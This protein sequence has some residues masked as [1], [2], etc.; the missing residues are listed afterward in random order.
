MTETFQQYI[1]RILDPVEHESEVVCADIHWRPVL[2]QDHRKKI[3]DLLRKEFPSAVD[4]SSSRESTLHI[5]VAGFFNFD[6]ASITRPDYLLLLDNNKNQKDFWLCVVETLRISDSTAEFRQNFRASTRVERLGNDP[7]TPASSLYGIYHPD[8]GNVARLRDCDSDGN[9]LEAY[10]SHAAWLQDEDAYQYL[11]HMALTGKIASAV[12]D[13]EKDTLRCATLGA[14]VKKL[15]MESQTC[16]WSNI[17]CYMHP[18]I[19]VIAGDPASE[20][21]ISSHEA[22]DVFATK[23]GGLHYPNSTFYS[24]NNDALTPA[25]QI[26]TWAGNENGK[27]PPFEQFLRNISAIGNS[28]KTLHFLTEHDNKIPLVVTDG[29][30]RGHHTTRLSVERHR[31]EG[32]GRESPSP[33]TH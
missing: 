25:N 30:P 16:Y 22:A 26:V 2:E 29:P 4:N 20:I 24:Q 14:A 3:L 5:G 7:Y 18:R 11:R 13:L 12:I 23:D 28:K 19:T 9:K 15:G 32:K 10:L 17:G 8:N 21:F 6:I 1:D 27:T 31:M 33:G